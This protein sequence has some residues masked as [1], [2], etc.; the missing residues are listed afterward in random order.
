MR[1]AP[2]VQLNPGSHH[3]LRPEPHSTRLQNTA[4]RHTQVCVTCEA[5]IFSTFCLLACETHPHQRLMW[6]ALTCAP[7]RTSDADVMGW[8]WPFKVLWWSP[9]PRDLRVRLYLESELSKRDEVMKPLRQ[10]VIQVEWHHLGHRKWT[11]RGSRNPCQ[12]RPRDTRPK[13]AVCKG[14]RPQKKPTLPTLPSETSGHQNYEQ[15]PSVAEAP[16]SAVC[17]T[18]ALLL[19]FSRV[20]LSVTPWTTAHGLP[21]PSLSPRACS[22]SCPS[23]QW[24]HPTISSSVIPSSSC[25]Q[26]FPASG[27]FPVSRLFASGGQS[28]PMVALAD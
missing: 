4:V 19:L 10:A 15:S 22:N 17:D 7:L 2:P 9:D 13:V 20:Q 27:S 28:V 3:S 14:E 6:E 5:G 25:L 24:C 26:S 23:S 21:G 18:V 11:Q 8:W 16:W 12:Q 1:W